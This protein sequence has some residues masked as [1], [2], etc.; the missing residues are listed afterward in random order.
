MGGVTLPNAGQRENT[1]NFATWFRYLR[2]WIPQSARWVRHSVLPG[3]WNE[4]GHTLGK[5]G[6]RAC[7]SC[8]NKPLIPSLFGSEETKTKAVQDAVYG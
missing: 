4:S 8:L 5:L 6:L 3:L 7:Y 2:G 1:A